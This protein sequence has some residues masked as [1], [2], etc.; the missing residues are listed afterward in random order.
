M[1]DDGRLTRPQTSLID[2]SVHLAL[3]LLQP[4]HVCPQIR[5]LRLQSI[6]LIM[7]RSER[8]I[9]R[10]REQ[11]RRRIMP[12]RLA[13]ATAEPVRHL[14]SRTSTARTTGTHR[15]ARIRTAHALWA[16]HLGRLALARIHPAR[17]FC[18]RVA[19]LRRLIAVTAVEWSRSVAVDGLCRVVLVGDVGAGVVV[20]GTVGFAVVARVVA[21]DVGLR[22]AA[23]SAEALE[24][25]SGGRSEKGGGGRRGSGRWWCLLRLKQLR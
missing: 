4:L 1:G 7:V 6:D 10:L 21:V 3:L 22:V 25:H 9:E 11:V 19:E 18:Q 17:L 14:A 8:S 24:E 23:R 16:H 20:A 12:H 15:R 13:T 5:H 2:P